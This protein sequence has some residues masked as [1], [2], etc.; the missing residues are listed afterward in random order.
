MKISFF[1]QNRIVLAYLLTLVFVLC[2]SCD[3][4]EDEEFLMV[5]E[6]NISLSEGGSS[7][8]ITVS[9]SGKWSATSDQVWLK[10]VNASGEG[11]GSITVEIE[12]N[13][14]FTSRT[15]KITISSEGAGTQIIE[16]TQGAAIPFVAIDK[17]VLLFEGPEVRTTTFQIT[18][19]VSWTIDKTQEWYNIDPVSGEGDALITVEVQENFGISI[20]NEAV[21]ISNAEFGINRNVEVK[22]NP[23]VVVVAGGNGLGDALDQLNF[24]S[25]LD[26]D[27][28]G[29]LFI[30]DQFNHRVVKW[31]VNSVEGTLVAGGIGQGSSLLQLDNPYGIFIAENGDMIISD[32]GNSRILRW[33][34]EDDAGV[35]IAGG[36]GPGFNLNQLNAPSSVH[37]TADNTVFI[38][39]SGNDRTVKWSDGAIVGEEVT[40]GGGFPAGVFLDQDENVYIASDLNNSIT[41]WEPGATNGVVVAGGNGNGSELNQF[42]D[43]S[44][45]YV[46]DQGNVFVADQVNNRVVKWAPGAAEGVIVAGGNGR[47]GEID[48]L[49]S[50]SGVRLDA[51]GNIYVCDQANN[52]IVKWLK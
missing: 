46:D 30:T 39:D 25:S 5:S 13:L 17:E 1:R 12:E 51:E 47:G 43:I 38:T 31:S 19:N 27:N 52:R 45:I 40:G 11:N 7:K 20:R 3:K 50:P 28:A 49:N 23:R 18:S 24:P 14:E 42:A 4:D 9:A 2:S 16:I 29:N 22:Q 48:Q 21:L 15:G 6:D 8:Q 36:N 26:V 41:K 34:P 33:K 37:L 35:I 10:I 44:G 32:N